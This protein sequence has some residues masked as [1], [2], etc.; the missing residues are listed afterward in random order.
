VTGGDRTREDRGP[1]VFSSKQFRVFSP[2]KFANAVGS[3]ALDPHIAYNVPFSRPVIG[4][5]ASPR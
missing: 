1:P 3:P 2:S 4:R 5:T